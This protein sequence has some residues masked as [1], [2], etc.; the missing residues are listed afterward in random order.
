MQPDP[1]NETYFN[2][3]DH[4]PQNKTEARLW[5]YIQHVQRKTEKLERELI[6]TQIR[7][8]ALENKRINPK[9]AWSQKK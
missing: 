1:E 3:Q 5:N 9:L 6:E 7:L 2:D 4:S 8:T